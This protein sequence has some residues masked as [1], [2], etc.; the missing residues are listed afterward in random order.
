MLQSERW[1]VILAELEAR[2]AVSVSALARQL[3]VSEMTIRRDLS[4]L[5]ARGT[6]R[7]IYGGAVSLP[8][9][10][11]PATV[12][13]VLN[14]AAKGAI[15]AE[16][17]RR[18]ADG[19]TVVLDS[20][21]T[22]AAVARH[23]RGRRL[24]VITTSLIVV[25]EL[26]DDPG[27]EVHLPGGRYRSETQSLTGPAAWEGLGDLRADLAFVGTSAIREASFFNHHADDVPIQRRM[28]DMA[29]EVWLLADHTKLDA[30]ALGRVGRLDQLSGVITD[31][32]VPD[33]GLAR[34]REWSRQVVTAD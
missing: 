20:G 15:G 22:V 21:T 7:K 10:D 1:N 28:M 9:P 12:R 4:A 31:A 33:A 25:R 17:A 19:A 34:L 8:L 29:E 16:A 14:V 13:S 26:A 3:T 32:S 27:I 2:Q 6:V 11:E 24:T 23:L 30:V 18:V 5:A